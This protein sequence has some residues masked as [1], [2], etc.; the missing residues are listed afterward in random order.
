MATSTTP[1]ISTNSPHPAVTAA[2]HDTAPISP[3]LS[4]AIIGAGIAGLSTLLSLHLHTPQHTLTVYESHPGGFTETGA[5]VNF[6]SNASRA[7]G[8]LCPALLDAYTRRRTTN[9]APRAWMQFCDAATEEG[10]V[11]VEDETAGVRGGLRRADFLEEL[12]RLVPEGR[13]RFGKRLVGFEEVRLGEKV[14]VEVRFADGSTAVHDA[15]IG[16][17][18][19]KSQTRRLLLGN[20]DPAEK[21]VYTGQYCYRGL[22]SIE[23]A[24]KVLGEQRARNSHLYVGRDRHMVT[25]P[26]A[27][28]AM[29]NFAAFATSENWDREE[30]VVPAESG[31]AVAREF[32]VFGPRLRALVALVRKPDI[33]ALFDHLPATTY[34]K[35]RVVLVGDA[36]HSSTPHQGAGAGMAVEDALLLGRLLGGVTEAGQLEAAF[37][38]FDHVRRPRTQELV[39]TSREAGEIYA[40]RAPGVGGDLGKIREKLGGRMGWIWYHDHEAE[41]EEARRFFEERVGT[42]DG[43]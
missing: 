27:G 39:R 3:P 11:L 22:V 10:V 28:G 25:Y 5:G 38:A 7:M 14:G 1:P 37:A 43:R 2:A 40:F 30:W 29:L 8:L 15:V 18:G 6:S 20:E 24:V 12:V 34:C 35:G 9:A 13:A 32:E 21:A 26:V 36:A 42:G 17:D 31:E 23:D 33:W 41:L 16:C 19:I 4:I